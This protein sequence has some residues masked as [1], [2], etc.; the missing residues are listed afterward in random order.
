MAEK[1]SSRE[2]VLLDWLPSNASREPTLRCYFIHS[3][4]HK[5][6]NRQLSQG[7]MSESERHRQ[8]GILTQLSKSKLFTDNISSYLGLIFRSLGRTTALIL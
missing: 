8:N 6:W 5:S 4:K 1:A 2:S 7:R 3:Q